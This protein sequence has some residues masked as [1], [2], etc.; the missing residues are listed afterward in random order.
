MS[1]Y[2]H[3]ETKHRRNKISPEEGRENG[4][5]TSRMFRFELTIG[6]RRDRRSSTTEGNRAISATKRS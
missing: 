2:V 6:K 5:V 1:E 4:L 3:S